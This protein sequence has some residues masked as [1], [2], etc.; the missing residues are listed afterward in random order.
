[1]YVFDQ[2]TDNPAWLDRAQQAVAFDDMVIAVKGK[3]PWQA[4]GF[5]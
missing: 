2:D 1:M 3:G 4:S 5:Q